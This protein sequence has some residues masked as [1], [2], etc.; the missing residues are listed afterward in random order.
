MDLVNDILNEVHWDPNDLHSPHAQKLQAPLQCTENTTFARAKPL[1]VNPP[2]LLTFCDGYIDDLITMAVDIDN[3]ITRAQQAPPLTVHT[4]FRPL[5]PDEPLPRSDPISLRKL[6]G[7]GQPSESKIVLGWKIC[8]R[9]FRVLLPQDKA[10]A[11]RTDIQNLLKPATRVSIKDMES[12]I[13]RLNHVGFIIPNARYFLNRLRRLFS[14]CQ[15]HGP[16]F[17]SK[18]ETRDLIFWL[19]VL[20]HMSKQGIS[21][22][23]ITYTK[24]DTILISDACEHGISGYNRYSGQAWRFKLTNWMQSQFT[25]NT[26][27]FLAAVITIWIECIHNHTTELRILSLTDSTSAP[28]WLYKVNFFPDNQQQQDKIA[29]KLALILMHRVTYLPKHSQNVTQ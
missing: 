21:I 10:L 23:N 22:N 16:Q 14:R 28:G 29:R 11:W 1:A 17:I 18:L 2:L 19:E 20:E 6:S 13:G 24:H 25:I 12:L 26:L 5:D 7:E 8:T 27:E 4:I 15:T 9:L 3:N